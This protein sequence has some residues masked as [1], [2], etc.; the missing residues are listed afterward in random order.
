MSD[1]IYT[2]LSTSFAAVSGLGAAVSAYIAYQVFIK[3]GEPKI[4]VYSCDKKD[5]PTFMLI[6]IENI[7][8][9][10]ASNV[11]FK[12]SR[13]IP[14]DTYADKSKTMTNGP[15]INGIPLLAPGEHRDVMWGDYKTL[16][17]VI[18]DDPITISYTYDYGKK[19][20][21]GSS[22]V[23]VLSFLNT[24]ASKTPISV[25]ADRVS[26]ISKHLGAILLKMNNPSG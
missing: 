18:G 7:G 22:Q 14:Y 10:V 16:A 5:S 12:S 25:V 20:L 2:L 9:D 26:E 1:Q 13:S 17:E 11:K 3:Q 23:E 8:R 21:K 6:R 19:E 4:I 24:P 15:L